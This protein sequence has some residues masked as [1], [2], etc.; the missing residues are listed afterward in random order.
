MPNFGSRYDIYSLPRDN[1]LQLAEA[2][3]MVSKGS[4]HNVFRLCMDVQKNKVPGCF[5]EC[6]TWRGGCVIVMAYAAVQFTI[7]NGEDASRNLRRKVWGF[8]SF[9]GLPKVTE[10][11]GNPGQYTEGSL[12]VSIESVDHAIYWTFRLRRENVYLVKG[13]FNTTLP[14]CK[15]D[16]GPIAVLRLDGDWYQSTMDTL[17]NLYDQVSVGGYVI[18]DDY[19][20]WPGCRKATN[21]FFMSRGWLPEDFV[22]NHFAPWLDTVPEGGQFFQKTEER[23]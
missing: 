2:W 4:I 12:A 1:V 10:K 6:G 9:E 17:T 16:M 14:R 7:A 5:V 11:D 8:D 15:D 18:I 20:A 13:W 21:E 23:V 3:S 22:T 19:G